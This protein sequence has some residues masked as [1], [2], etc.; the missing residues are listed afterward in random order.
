MCDS[1]D[2][3]NEV[4]IRSLGKLPD[5]RHLVLFVELMMNVVVSFFRNDIFLL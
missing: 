2:I 3:A 5:I 4:K 1:K